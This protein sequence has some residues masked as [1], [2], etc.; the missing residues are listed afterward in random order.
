[1]LESLRRIV[2]EVNA[3]P[4]LREVLSIIVARVRA[5]MNTEVCSV[6]LR[7]QQNVFVMMATEGLKSAAVGRVQLA[8]GEGL[9]GL[10]A[11]REESLNLDNASA[12]PKSRR[13]ATS[14]ITEAPNG[15]PA[16]TTP[17]GA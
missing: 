4:N 3:A 8:C 6:Y 14:A 2:Q 5:S 9:V 12:H 7:N 10:V 13:A 16:P 11:Q 17:P 1:M 15:T